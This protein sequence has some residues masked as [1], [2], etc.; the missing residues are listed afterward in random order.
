MYLVK[1]TPIKINRYNLQE[2]IHLETWRS[3]EEII[4]KGP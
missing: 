2:S 3:Y 1:I 4:R